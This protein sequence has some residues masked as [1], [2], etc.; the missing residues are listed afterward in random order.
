MIYDVEFP[1]G[2][3]KEYAANII[4]ENMYAQ[5]DPDGHVH[6][7]L[8]SIIDFKKDDKALSKD[9]LYVTTKSGRRR[10]RETT[11][12]WNFLI[13]FKDGSEVWMPLK[14]LKESNPLEVAEFVTARGIAEEPAFCWW[15]PYTLRR[16]DRIIATVNK[17]IKRVSHK[18]GV[19]VP[20]SIE[21]AYR[22][23]RANKN[24][25]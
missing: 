21:H 1:D 14:R 23:D 12:G 19:E 11:S 9:D 16:R 25:F 4:A 13:Q 18:Y 5:V 15:V 8:D 17:R 20:T 6:G 7:I 3:I 2:T 22:I 24:T 10:I